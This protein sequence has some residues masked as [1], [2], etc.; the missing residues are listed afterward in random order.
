MRHHDHGPA[1]HPYR[2]LEQ[3]Q[4]IARTA[5]VQRTGRLVREDHPGFG[6]ERTGD[7]HTLPL[8]SGELV[9]QVAEPVTETDGR[10]DLLDP[11]TVD[12]PPG[13]P[14]RQDRVLRD[15]QRR[16]QV[17]L[18]EHEADPAAPEPRQLGLAAARHLRAVHHHD[19]AVGPVEP[20]RALQQRGLAGPRGPHHGGERAPR[21]AERHPVQGGHGTLPGAER[22]ADLDQPQ[23]LRGGS[24]V[25]R[26]SRLAKHRH[27]SPS[28]TPCA[29]PTT[30]RRAGPGHMGRRTRI[31]GCTQ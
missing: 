18:L 3:A 9:G 12:A 13:E 28:G 15:G 6:D 30:L 27:H 5:R 17:V 20:G 19:A 14:E 4:H 26:T 24:R 8:S 22:P 25:V 16:Q 29:S 2:L 21:Q 11:R 7:G 23:S 31:P 1:V 10:Q